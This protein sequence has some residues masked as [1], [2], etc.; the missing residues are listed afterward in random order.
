MS[1]DS[2]VEKYKKVFAGEE[3]II[4]AGVPLKAS[5]SDRSQIKFWNGGAF[6]RQI[7]PELDEFLSER[8]SATILDY[9][10]GP[11][12]HLYINV[13]MDKTGKGYTTYSR[14]RTKIQTYYCYDPG[15][16]EYEKKP[17]VGWTFDCIISADVLEH[18]YEQDIPATLQE[19]YN[20]QNKDGLAI[21]SISAMPSYNGCMFADGTDPHV[22]IKPLDWWLDKIDKVYVD[23]KYVVVYDMPKPGGDFDNKREFI[24]IIRKN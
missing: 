21:L 6:T 20:Y 8:T 7:V 16:P 12:Q 13:K 22:T 15:L 4:R 9:G 11:A 18:I 10:C 23:K 14:Y 24:T 2:L 1:K 19:L 5:S 17:P 3:P